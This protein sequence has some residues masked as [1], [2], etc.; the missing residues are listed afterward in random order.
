MSRFDFYDQEASKR[1][2]R[3]AADLLLTE[4]EK[5]HRDRSFGLLAFQIEIRDGEP[6]EVTAN[7]QVRVRASNLAAGDE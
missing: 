3:Y 7:P 2:A 4:L 1:V 5:Y 6:F